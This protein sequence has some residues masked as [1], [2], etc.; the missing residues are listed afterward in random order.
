MNRH[1]KPV[2]SLADDKL[3]LAA[4][5]IRTLTARDLTSVAGGILKS[6][7]ASSDTVC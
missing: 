4:E 3:S 7:R 2:R 5:T 1:R 6:H